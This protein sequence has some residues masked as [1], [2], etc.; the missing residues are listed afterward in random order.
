MTLERASANSFRLAAIGA[1]RLV[2]LL[3]D[4]ARGDGPL[5]EQ[6]ADQMRHLIRTGAMTSG[7]RLPSERSLGLALNLSRNTVTKSLDLLRGEGLLSSRQGDGT[8]VTVSRR[9]SGP[10]RGDDRLRSFVAEDPVQLDRIDL[11]SAAMPGLAM[12]ADE[13][14]LLDGSRMRE[15]VASHG[16]IPSGLPELREAIAAY[17]RGLGLPTG[18]EHILVCSGAQQALRLVASSFITPGATVLIEEPSFRG[19]I[20]S[21]QALG[22]RL[23][24]VSSGGDGI[25]VDELAAAV[26]ARKPALI[27]LQSTVHNPTG[28]VLDRFHRSRITAI[29]ERSGVPVIDDATLSDTIIDGER[30]PI[31]LAAGSDLVLTVGSMSKSFWGGLRL[32]WV[33]AQPETIDELI[34]VKGGEDLGTSVLAQLLAAQLL[35]QIERAR[36]ERFRTLTEGRRLALEQLAEQLPDWTPQVPAG[37]GSLWIR[38]PGPGATA[39]AQRAERVGVQILPGPTFSAEDRLDDHVRLSYAADQGAVARGIDLLAQVWSEFG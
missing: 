28:S 35:P 4:W 38:L 22:A 23:V 5:H 1:S 24:G 12:V 21:L 6:L 8:Y 36:D 30:R 14:N 15:L 20:E 16:Y 34:A 32:G 31:P 10:V 26:A 39:F 3:G 2:R 29:A 18:P 27:V 17:Y 13:V 9:H 33:R 7:T 19:A 11:R 37:G 25:D